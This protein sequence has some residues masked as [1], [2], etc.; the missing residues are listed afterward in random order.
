[1]P[2][3]QGSTQVHQLAD[4]LNA[5]LQAGTP[6]RA[7]LG[8]KDAAF[9]WTTGI[10]RGFWTFCNTTS[11][12]GSGFTALKVLPSG[13]PV[14]KVLE[15]GTK[16]NAVTL[17]S[18]PVDLAKFAGLAQFSMEKSLYS[19]VLVQAVVSTLINGALAALET[20]C[21]AE[22]I[23]GAG[24]TLT[25]ATS[26]TGAVLGGIAAV[27]GNG[28]TPNL[29][30]MSAADFASA[31]EGSVGLSFSGTDAVLTFLGLQ[32]HISPAM[33]AGTA[34][35]MDSRALLIGESTQSPSVTCDPYTLAS[36]NE[37]RVIADLMAAPVVTAG[38][39][40]VAITPTIAPLAAAAS[41]STTGG[42]A[43]K[44]K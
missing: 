33:A 10:A 11:V 42:K 43:T 37:I 41:S 9:A 39:S 1:M 35:V 12:E 34:V 36:T 15:G 4:Q 13:T 18:D 20:D 38:G 31:V 19:D 27:A 28:G 22:V 23:A 21:A 29:L 7:T 2:V 5:S 6:T 32:V 16:N 3:T 24:E 8:A 14:G 17:V 44:A 30:A 40:V 26:W 25:D